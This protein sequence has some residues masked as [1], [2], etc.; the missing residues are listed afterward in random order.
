MLTVLQNGDLGFY[1]TDKIEQTLTLNTTSNKTGFI[2]A[3]FM[4]GQKI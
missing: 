1:Q 3:K 2:S 4:N